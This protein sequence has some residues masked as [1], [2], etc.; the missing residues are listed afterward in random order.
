MPN[1]MTRYYYVLLS[2]HNFHGTLLLHTVHCAFF[3]SERWC[4]LLWPPWHY[5]LD[6]VISNSPDWKQDNPITDKTRSEWKISIL[7][8]T[9]PSPERQFASPEHI[10]IIHLK[11]LQ[12]MGVSPGENGN[13]FGWKKKPP[14]QQ[15]RA[16]SHCIFSKNGQIW[17]KWIETHI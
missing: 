15:F 14:E 9:I 4:R 17:I 6:L 13:V 7:L 8:K 12:K 16:F 10:F 5:V 1:S 3:S 11:K 2:I